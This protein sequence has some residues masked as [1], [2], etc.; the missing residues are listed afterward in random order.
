MRV[1]IAF[2]SKRGGTEGLAG[3][4]GS[5]LAA[6]GME[7]AVQPARAVRSLD[8]FDAV[9]I[10]GALYASRW[11]GDARRFTR[12]HAK[13]LRALPV[14]LV[15]SGPLDDSALGGDIPPV[16]HVA[17]AMSKIGARGQV[18]FGGRLEADAKGFPASAIARTKAG[19]WRDPTHVRSWASAVAE[20]LAHLADTAGTQPTPSG[21]VGRLPQS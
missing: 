21:A 15:S 1:L 16:K 19:D 5:E 14:W 13:T 20:D 12:R 10:A 7:T 11:H 2:G 18:T 4:I 3:M 8:G 17:S 6:A 9:V